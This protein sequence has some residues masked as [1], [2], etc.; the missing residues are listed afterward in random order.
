MAD[1]DNTNCH[2]SL[3]NNDD[4]DVRH[5][6]ELCQDSIKENEALPIHAVAKEL[7]EG[8]AI[9]PLSTSAVAGAQGQIQ[10]VA[11]QMD[12]V[13]TQIGQIGGQLPDLQLQAKALLECTETLEKTY[14][15][16]DELALLVDM[17]ATSVQDVNTKMEEAERELSSTALQP[18]HA[19]LETLK[20]GPKGFRH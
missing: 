3:N 16:I 11:L 15:R 1:N 2:N 17:V 13:R 8:F 9:E 7:A 4:L 5:S 20:M 18:L 6:Q 14:R 12:G 10:T 19:V